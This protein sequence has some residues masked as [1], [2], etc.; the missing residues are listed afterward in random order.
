MAAIRI[1]QS[2]GLGGANSLNDVKTVQTA[3]NKLLKLIPPTQTLIVDGRLN[4]RPESSKTI[5]AIKLFQSKVLNMVR[6]D[7]KINPN[8]AIFRKINEKLALFN[9]QKAGMKDPQLF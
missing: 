9:S 8:D 3:L 4:P 6:P 5:A 7:G 1:T 2:V